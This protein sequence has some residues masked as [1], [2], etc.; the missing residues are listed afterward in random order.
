M[1][2]LVRVASLAFFAAIFMLAAPVAMARPRWKSFLANGKNSKKYTLAVLGKMPDSG[3][4][5]KSDPAAM[6]FK[7]QMNHIF[8]HGDISGIPFR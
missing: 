4:D 7:D 5:Y 8:N 2:R 1:K 6:Y 3:M